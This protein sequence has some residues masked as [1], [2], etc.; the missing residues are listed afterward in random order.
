M[1]A[2]SALIAVGLCAGFSPAFSAPK[3]LEDQIQEQVQK[4]S[5]FGRKAW[6]LDIAW[7][8]VEGD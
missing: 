2:F 4:A 7:N 8:R 6:V 3:T 5:K 1:K